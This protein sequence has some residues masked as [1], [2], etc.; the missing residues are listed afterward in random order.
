MGN[1]K[2]IVV[3]LTEDIYLKISTDY[4]ISYSL[5]FKVIH[6]LSSLVERGLQRDKLFIY[7]NVKS[8]NLK[9]TYGDR[10]YRQVITYCV[11]HSYI[12]PCN[13]YLK[14]HYSKSYKLN[15][16]FFK[17]R[18]F[19]TTI[20]ARIKE[21]PTDF[22]F[23]PYL[24]YVSFDSDAQATLNRHIRHFR[25][26]DRIY[27][28]RYSF[29][30][31]LNERF[32]VRRHS[33]TGRVFT[34]ITSLPKV[35]RRHVLLCGEATAE[36]DIKNSQPFLAATLYPN[37]CAE[38][39]R[40]LELVKSGEFYEAINQ[41][42]SVPYDLPKKRD[43]LKCRIFKEVFFGQALNRY[44]ALTV[45]S[46]LF[47]ELSAIIKSK[48]KNGNTSALPLHLQSI[49]AR[50][51]IGNVH[52][53]AVGAGVPI[54]TIHDS[55]LVRV[56]DVDRV[57]DWIKEAFAAVV[58]TAPDLRVSRNTMVSNLKPFQATEQGLPL[59][60][61]AEAITIQPALELQSSQ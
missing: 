51:M 60:N 30:G 23:Q 59:V 58:G 9:R 34:N 55:A 38:K 41:Q 22:T 13:H 33:E 47:P 39:A 57:A 11:A 42:L 48:K 49:E 37:S 36:I 28:W 4:C 40:Y 29:N 19:S 1:F 12:I 24:A 31:V 26:F 45:F 3:Y 2:S 8:K 50:A 5:R 14:G 10:Y 32:W 15:E 43:N 16:P 52:T 46:N 53:R 25:S 17:G 56:R 27:A 20:S 35:L 61:L 54:I 18:L 6:F 7:Y 21:E 44:E